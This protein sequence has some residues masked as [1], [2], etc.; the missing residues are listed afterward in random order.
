MGRILSPSTQKVFEMIPE[1]KGFYDVLKRGEQLIFDEFFGEIEQYR[2]AISNTTNL[3]PMEIL[4]W[5]ILLAEHKKNNQ[6]INEIYGRLEKLENR[7]KELEPPEK[8]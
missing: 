8:P 6:I 7:L 2:A 1:L 4:L 5:A 3:L